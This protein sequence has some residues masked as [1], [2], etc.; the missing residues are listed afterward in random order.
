MEGVKD[1]SKKVKEIANAEITPY[2]EDIDNFI[3]ECNRMLLRGDAL[4]DKALE[5]IV[6]NI[7]A[8]LYYLGTQ[9]E[10]LMADATIA[11]INYRNQLSEHKLEAEGTVG[12]RQSKAELEVA[13]EEVAKIVFETAVAL[14]KVRE[15]AAIELLQSAKKII[16]S[17][18]EQL[19]L[20]GAV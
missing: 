7:P 15:E 8:L 16:N 6:I 5:S 13:E 17:R 19:K 9:R 11:K 4:S 20:T 10:T 3:N 18:T 1:Y 14:M 12:D 2:V